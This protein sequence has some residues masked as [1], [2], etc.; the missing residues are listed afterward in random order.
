MKKLYIFI[1]AAIGLASCNFLEEENFTELDGN[2]FFNSID[3][4]NYAV[5]G[6]YDGLQSL[7]VPFNYMTE[8]AS[9]HTCVAQSSKN[10]NDV[11][12]QSGTITYN[13]NTVIQA[14]NRLYNII[15]SS[16]LVIDNIDKVAMAATVRNKFLG[17]ARFMRGWCYVM[18]ATLYKDVPLRT[19]SEYKTGFYECAL[20]SQSDIYDF[21]L[22]DLEFAEENLFDFP[23]G[24]ALEG[25]KGEY[26]TKERGRVSRETAIGVQALAYMYRAKNDPAS[27]YWTQARAKALQLIEMRG[28]L[29]A[30]TSWLC[31]KYGDLFRAEG[32]YDKEVLFG[33]YF[34]NIKGEGTGMGNNWA[35]HMRYSKGQYAGFRR[36]TLDWYTK[37]FANKRDNRN[38]DMI[39][40][41]FEMANNKFQYWPTSTQFPIEVGKNPAVGYVESANGPFFKK[42]DD[43]G[44]TIMNTCANGLHLL[45]YADVLLIF[46]EAENEVN[47][48]PSA[49]AYK[50]I[51]AVRERAGAQATPVAPIIGFY[52]RFWGENP[53]PTDEGEANTSMTCEEFRTAVLD[54]RYMEFFEESKR[55]FDLNRREFYGEALAATQECDEY[56]KKNVTRNNRTGVKTYYF[57]IPKTEVDANKLISR[58]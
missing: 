35:I 55:L 57:P 14:W 50:A 45:R 22:K 30:A 46:A 20:S 17:E 6:C 33:I 44:A 56:V 15:Y 36:Y 51:N 54:E 39:H 12:W 40:H 49:D 53:Y 52:P 13:D 37:Y 21:A 19:T 47:N 18:L 26:T 58:Q 41:E 23:Y 31:P 38:I 1:L 28:G 7:A 32:K 16:N 2:K 8:V 24:R 34:T 10:A 9:D 42:F 11:T 5:L 3:N 48:G 4:V 27:P 25:L 43:P 29:D